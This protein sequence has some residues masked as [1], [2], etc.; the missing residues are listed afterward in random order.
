[1]KQEEGVH[2][3]LVTHSFSEAL[4]T[5][6]TIFQRQLRYKRD[7]LIE[8]VTS[9]RFLCEKQKQI[10]TESAAKYLWG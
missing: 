10:T 3:T 4:R 7:E 6:R 1:M 9:H 5:E 8:A 2:V